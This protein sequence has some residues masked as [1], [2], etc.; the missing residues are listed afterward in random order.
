MHPLQKKIEK[1]TCKTENTGLS[2]AAISKAEL[3]QLGTRLPQTPANFTN[4]AL[5]GGCDNKGRL[6]KQAVASRKH[7]P[8]ASFAPRAKTAGWFRQQPFFPHP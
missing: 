6:K 4:P 8:A 7:K 1:N 2:S 5:P 3:R